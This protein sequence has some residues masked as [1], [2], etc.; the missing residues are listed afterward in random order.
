MPLSISLLLEMAV[1]ANP[2]RPALRDHVRA[3][4]RGSRT[5][6]RVVFL[7]ELPVNAT[8]KLVRRDLVA[9][10]RSTS[11]DARVSAAPFPHEIAVR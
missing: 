8:G 3:Q 2:D 4:L 7:D 6:D 9:I 5:P 10:L 11:K 1:S